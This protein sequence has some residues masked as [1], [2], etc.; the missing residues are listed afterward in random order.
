MFATG[1]VCFSLD[2][3][4]F[5]HKWVAIRTSEHGVGFG[6]VRE[7]FLLCVHF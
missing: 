1:Y 2:S 4:D 7:V 3:L 6:I 5:Y